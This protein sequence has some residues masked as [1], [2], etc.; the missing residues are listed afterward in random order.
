M[1]RAERTHPPV[2]GLFAGRTAL[3]A[4]LQRHLLGKGHSS[5]AVAIAT[6]IEEMQ[7][8]KF[9]LNLCHHDLRDVGVPIQ[10]GLKRVAQRNQE[11]TP[12]TAAVDVIHRRVREQQRIAFSELCDADLG[13]FCIHR[14]L[15]LGGERMIQ[16]DGQV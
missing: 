13:C 2:A 6:V 7:L 8:A 15:A 5:R 16:A 3:F 14:V 11:V 12:S 10:V 9:R 1:H 4:G